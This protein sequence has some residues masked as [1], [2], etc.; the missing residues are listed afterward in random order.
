LLVGAG[1]HEVEAK[2]ATRSF[3]FA[4]FDDYFSGTEAGAGISGQEYVKLPADVQNA[5]REE[6]RLSFPEGDSRKPF[7]VEMEVLVGTGR[8]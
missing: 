2:S 7:V 6:V 5:V 3:S 4:S 8:K 1:F